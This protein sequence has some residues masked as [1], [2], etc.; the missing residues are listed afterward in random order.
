MDLF[1]ICSTGTDFSI[2]AHKISS[3]REVLWALLLFGVIVVSLKP[4][5]KTLSGYSGLLLL[6]CLQLFQAGDL[7]LFEFKTQLLLAKSWAVLACFMA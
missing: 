3:G 2:R 4:L 6:Y 7:F 1:L 5:P